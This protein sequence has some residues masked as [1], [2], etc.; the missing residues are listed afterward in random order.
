M[1]LMLVA[2]AIFGVTYLLIITEW[3]NKMLAALMGGFAIVLTGIVHQE[4]AF[5][6]IDW[7]VI[8]FLIDCVRPGCSCIW[9][10]A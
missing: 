8:F 1:T 6:A 7:N 5:A 10:S 4:I 3:I 2:L 9:P